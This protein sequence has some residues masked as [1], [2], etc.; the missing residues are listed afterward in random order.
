MLALA[1]LGRRIVICGPSNA[2]K[3][4]LARAISIKLG[5]PP[6]YLDLLHH[7]PGTDYL[8]RPIDEFHRL[9]AQAIAG[10]AWVMEGNYFGLIPQRL[11]RATGIILLGSEPW[12]GLG[13]YVRRTLFERDGAGRLEGGSN[14]LNWEMVRII[15]V[16]QPRK[17][18]RDTQIL[19]AS[20]LPMVA[21]ASLRA[22][23]SLYE[24]WGLAR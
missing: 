10:D 13:R 2:G 14:R 5:I 15:T 23:N 17:R 18:R 1:D 7:T 11:S 21:P 4:T 8:P 9:H 6:V 20:R 3:S 16:N 19:A 22:L 12:R 24:D